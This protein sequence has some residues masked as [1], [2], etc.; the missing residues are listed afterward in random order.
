MFQGCVIYFDSDSSSTEEVNGGDAKSPHSDADL[1]SA[2]L[3]MRM[4]SNTARFAGAE[5]ATSLEDEGV[6]H[7]VVVVDC[8]NDGDA[9]G[10]DKMRQ[11]TKL[12]KIRESLKT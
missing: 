6:T 9:H 8:D 12:R 5:V 11:R 7:V 3:R 4:A 1:S 10:A 2:E